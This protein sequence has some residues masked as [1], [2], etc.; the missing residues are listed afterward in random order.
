MKKIVNP[1]Y[2]LVNEKKLPV[3]AQI[4]LDNGNLSITGVIAPRDNGSAYCAG[5]IGEYLL[6]TFP[7]KEEGWDAFRLCD[8][9]LICKEWHLNNLTAGSPRQE[10][11]LKEWTSRNKYSYE[12][13]CEALKEANLYEDAEYLHNGKPYVYGTAWLRRELP[14][15]VIDFLENLTETKNKPAWI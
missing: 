11:F 3:Y 5:Q 15:E 9:A 4:N 13:A 7:N 10:A 1:G 12:K 6:D 2:I 8:F 14:Q